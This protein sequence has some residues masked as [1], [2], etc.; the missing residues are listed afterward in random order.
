MQWVPV[1]AEETQ[2]KHQGAG[3]HWSAE[4]Q[5]NRRTSSSASQWRPS[6]GQPCKLARQLRVA[7]VFLP[8]AAPSRCLGHCTHKSQT[9]S[10]Q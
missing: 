2:E 1:F 3:A 8:S 4:P 10:V 7:A 6:G 9:K 5:M